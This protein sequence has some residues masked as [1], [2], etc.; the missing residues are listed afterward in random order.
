VL[1]IVE[2]AAVLAWLL[3]TRS[4]EGP[5]AMTTAFRTENRR[6]EDGRP[7]KNAAT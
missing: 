1:V 6:R 3:A 4:V 2:P 7:W 5:A